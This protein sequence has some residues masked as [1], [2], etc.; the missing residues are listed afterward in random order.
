[1]RLLPELF[2]FLLMVNVG[3]TS[4]VAFS[5]PIMKPGSDSPS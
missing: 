4:R 2:G 3:M 5:N 1:M